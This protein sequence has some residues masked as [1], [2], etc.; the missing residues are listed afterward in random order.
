MPGVGRKTATLVM[1]LA[2][3][4]GQHICVDTHVHRI[5]NRLGWVQTRLPEQTEQALYRSH[6]RALVAVAQSVS[7]HLGAECLPPGV[8]SVW[9]MR[10][11]RRLPAPRRRHIPSGTNHNQ[12][13]CFAGATHPD[14]RLMTT[15]VLGTSLIALFCGSLLLTV[16][17][18]AAAQTAPAP[19]P[20]RPPPHPGPG[21]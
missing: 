12:P 11:R 19:A 4:S 1:I 6:R 20:R 10:H 2:F 17:P 21:R 8:S 9:R 13:P 16:P 7:R 3:Q 18:R 14:M 5:S 15:K